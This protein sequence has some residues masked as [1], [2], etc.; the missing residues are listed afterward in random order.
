MKSTDEQLK[1]IRRGVVDIVTVE[2]L[3]KKL[4]KGKP[5]VI[6]LGIDPTSPDIHV[7]H[8]VPLIKMRQ[9]QDM[10]HK[11]V[12]IFGDYTAMIGDPSG[13]MNERPPLS[14]GDIKKNVK[15][16]KDQ[17]LKIL[18]KKNLE[19]V[20]NGSWF[21]KMKFNDVI[22]MVSKFTLAQMMEHDYFDKRFKE[23]VPL[24]LHELVYPIMQGYDSVMIKA[25]IELGGTD[26]RFNV[27][28][29]R[30]LQKESGAEPQA[31]LFTPILTGLDGK[32]KMSKSLN[33]YIGVNDEP[34]DMLGKVMSITDELI[35]RYFE[36]LTD[37]PLNE[38]KK[39]ED[40]MKNGANPRDSKILLAYNI[41]AKFH[42]E[43]KAK[44]AREH[45]EKTFSEK[46][47]QYDSHIYK[48]EFPGEEA[49]VAEL[50]KAVGGVS[51]NSEARRIVEQGGFYLNEKRINDFQL[52]IKKS[53]MPFTFKIGKKKFG[54]F[55]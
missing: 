45:F 52:K 30:Y 9:F 11:A 32:N 42:G 35:T 12:L 47:V 16:Y 20:Y 37:V 15:T 23:G 27:I 13:R 21:S 19:I 44:A 17:A 36:L 43:E 1:E 18:D 26:Q 8:T 4:K 14:A 33:N 25:D 48:W 41:T 5:L 6:K 29:G 38:V 50:F 28:A 40:E 55:E 54:K 51:S 24:S 2:D 7:G 22:K 34:E 31:G 49:G 39:M 3:E 53:D 46:D 10:G